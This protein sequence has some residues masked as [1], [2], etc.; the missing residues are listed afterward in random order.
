MSFNIANNEQDELE[1][2]LLYCCEGIGSE[3][4][5]DSTKFN[6]GT[7]VL[8]KKKQYTKHN[9]SKKIKTKKQS[10]LHFFCSLWFQTN[11]MLVIF[12]F[13]L[14]CYIFLSTFCLCLFYIFIY[15]CM[16]SILPNFS[17]IKSYRIFITS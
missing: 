13:S 10:I 15:F 12:F 9:Y 16:I 8:S 1:N 5:M 6:I 3:D 4:K 2:E 11:T 7:R 17:F 14:L